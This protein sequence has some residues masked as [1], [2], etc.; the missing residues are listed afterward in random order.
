MNT[1]AVLETSPATALAAPLKIGMLLPSSNSMAEPEIQR[2]LPPGVNILT[3][4]LKL[5]GSSKAALLGMTEKIEEASSLL[6]DA[7]VD[8][9]V[10]NCTAVS[11]FDPGMG[12]KL[13]SRIA[14]ASGCPATA[15]SDALLAAFN[16]LRAKRIVLITPY[17]EEVN[18]REVDYLEHFG[19]EVVSQVG[20]GLL[21]GTSMAAVPPAK[22][23]ELARNYRDDSTDIYFLSCTAINV[24]SIIETVEAELGRPVVTS[25]QAMLWHCLRL[26]GRTEPVR[27]FGKLFEM[28]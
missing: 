20:L 28:A 19:Y 17:I 24:S 14:E 9:I 16:V 2:M 13:S 22:W 7:A 26:L 4:R 27:G 23:L 25:N 3:T 18:L 1:H 12:E 8:L 15:T 10:F 21:E 11:T 6:A 5:A